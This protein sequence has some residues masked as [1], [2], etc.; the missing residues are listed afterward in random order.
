MSSDLPPPPPRPPADLGL[1]REDPPK[2]RQRR[3]WMQRLTIVA[4]FIA[5]FGSFAAA[6]ALYVGQRVVEDRNLVPAFEPQEVPANAGFEPGAQGAADGAA[7][8]PESDDAVPVETFPP[9]EPEA[10]NFLITGADNND[11]VDP[12]S[13]YAGAFGDRSSLGERSDTI[14]VWRVNPSTNQ[15]AVLSFPRDLWVTI[16]GRSS[17]QRINT[18]YDRD[19]PNLLRDTI[20]ANFF[21]PVDYFI[22]VDFCA[23]KT[24]VD[25]VGGV[26]VPFDTPVRDTNTGLNVPDAGCYTFD[27]DHALAY[28]RS[29]KLQTLNDD[30]TWSTDGTSDLGRISR[31]QDFIRRVAD[32][33][34]S[35]GAWDPSVARGLIDTSSDYET[36]S[37]DFTIAKQQE[38]AGVL[39]GLDPANITTYQIEAR[40]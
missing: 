12:D 25:A 40:G 15:V 39:S 5:A 32:E 38:I 1:T 35:T 21:V 6:S 29:R 28:V 19:D 18:A 24:L 11:C 8:A 16:P 23:F 13:P 31:Q 22:Q 10:R 9:A 14:M 33:L 27:G 17:Q 20:F 2:R 4:I 7:D 30:G 26:G 3:T 37:E 34:L 36:I